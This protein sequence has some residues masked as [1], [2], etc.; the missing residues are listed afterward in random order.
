MIAKRDAT[1]KDQRE[2][3]AQKKIFTGNPALKKTTSDSDLDEITNFEEAIKIFRETGNDRGM[4]QAI[5]LETDGYFDIGELKTALAAAAV[6]LPLW[7]KVRDR[8]FEAGTLHN[9][10]V[11]LSALGEGDKA[12]YFLDQSLAIFREEKNNRLAWGKFSRKHRQWEK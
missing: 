12:L 3:A 2:F 9:I 4:A 7:R 10:G 1:E 6:S 5:F 11:I 8:I